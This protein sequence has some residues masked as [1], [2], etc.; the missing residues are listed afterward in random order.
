MGDDA[1]ADATSID[2]LLAPLKRGTKDYLLKSIVPSLVQGLTQ[3]AI[4]RPEDPHVWLAEYL[5]ERSPEGRSMQI[6][7]RGEEAGDEAK[8]DATDDGAETTVSSTLTVG[9]FTLIVELHKMDAGGILIAAI[10][11]T[12]QKTGVLQLDAAAARTLPEELTDPDDTL[13]PESEVWGRLQDRLRCMDTEEGLDL[14]L[15][16]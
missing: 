8:G 1:A 6:V 16:E 14:M 10:D 2:H 13:T 9:D 5:L 11:K 7:K 12:S 4:V 15:V 3:M